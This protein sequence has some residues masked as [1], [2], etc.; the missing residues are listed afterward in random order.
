MISSEISRGAPVHD[1]HGTH[2]DLHSDQGARKGEHP[3]RARNPIT[4][5]HDLA[6]LEFCKPDL[7]RAETFAHAFG[8]ATTLRT[9]DELHLRGTD[10]GAPCVIIRKGP[11]SRFLGPAFKAAEATDVLRLAE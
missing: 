4:K 8:F 6:W 1:H 3:G 2:H 5:V 7:A 11:R 10:A 9:A